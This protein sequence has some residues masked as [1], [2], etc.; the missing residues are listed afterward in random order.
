[1]KCIKYYNIYSLGSDE[2]LNFRVIVQ[3]EV[4]EFGP[5]KICRH[6]PY[7]NTVEGVKPHDVNRKSRTETEEEGFKN[8]LR[9]VQHKLVHQP[10][11]LVVLNDGR[12]VICTNV[13]V[14]KQNLFIK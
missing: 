5:D 14:L 12:K 7:L 10:T 8:L 11:L 1:M 2:L 4:V 3:C 9:F 13:E 6:D